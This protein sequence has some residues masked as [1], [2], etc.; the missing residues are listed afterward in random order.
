ME[1]RKADYKVKASI[2]GACSE[3]SDILCEVTLPQRVTESI[4]LKFNLN[5]EIGHE[6]LRNFFKFSLYGEIKDSSGNP[7]KI[8]EAKEVYFQTGGTTKWDSDLSETVFFGD[9]FDLK[10]TT[11][12]YD[13]RISDEDSKLYQVI[14]WLTPCNA[15]SPVEV[16]TPSYT[17]EVTV[18]KNNSDFTLP[19]GYRL[20]FD[21]HYRYLKAENGDRISFPELVA[22]CKDIQ[23]EEN[24]E[25]VLQELDDFLMITSF[26]ERQRCVCLGYEEYYNNSRNISHYRKRA[27]PNFRANYRDALI[28]IRYFDEFISTAFESFQGSDRKDF[29]RQAIFRV[30]EEDGALESNFLSIFSSIETLVL[31]YQT[32]L[33][34]KTIFSDPEWKQIFEDTKKLFKG[35]NILSGDSNKTRRKE[36][37]EKI[38]ELNRASFPCTF[39]SF[40]EHYK[41]DM[42]DMWPVANK[43]DGVTLSEIRNKLIHG[44]PFTPIQE[45]CLLS[46]M[47]QL[48]WI[49]ERM[50]L[51]V[52]GWPIEK[53]QVSKDVFEKMNSSDSWQEKRRILTEN[54]RT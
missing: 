24:F 30:T 42:N 26:A 45:S 2:K 51:S 29:L 18:K 8:I 1:K 43:E 3:L 36:V 46:A 4:K 54:N 47:I 27:I 10:I 25:K 21:H 31:Y 6:Q 16:V 34:R 7:Q 23:R 39:D 35:H 44:D 50:I 41:L 19:C 32:T 38:P 22:E 33:C 52:F 28:D 5:K 12:I 14:F 15:L 40:C 53:S 20:L 48:K 37:Y 17:G 9:P 11:R 13:Q 49:T